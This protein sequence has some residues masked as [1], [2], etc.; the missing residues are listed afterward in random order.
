M[1]LN[2]N[3]DSLASRAATRPLMKPMAEACMDKQTGLTISN[4]PMKSEKTLMSLI[5]AF[6]N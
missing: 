5:F 4:W 6:N 2:G 3:L 1:I